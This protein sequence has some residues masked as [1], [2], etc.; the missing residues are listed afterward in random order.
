MFKNKDTTEEPAEEAE[1]IEPFEFVI[2]TQGK[3]FDEANDEMQEAFNVFNDG[4]KMSACTSFTLSGNSF[5]MDACQWI[6]EN[7]LINLHNLQKVDFSDIFTT[8]ERDKLPASLK[9]MIDAIIDKQIVSL[10]LSHNAFGPDGVSAYVE[11]LEKCPS[12]KI[13][14]VTNCGLGPQG[15]EMIAEAILK[16]EEMKLEE[17]SASRDRL[18][19]PGIEALSKVFS[20]H[21]T[22]KK[23]EVYQ[24]GIRK[25]L[26]H[27]FTALLDCAD[28]IEYVDVQ[29]NLIKRA[30]G[31]M[32]EFVKTCQK[33]K[34]FNISDTLIKKNQQKEV[35]DAIVESI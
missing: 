14:D 26:S 7:I 21:G 18:E 35:V 32:V 34:Y 4:D 5:G 6:A 10:K 23:I 12:L 20:A 8:R 2:P 27:L 16:N 33:V 13:L 1:P 3:F 29:D 22:L 25:G 31:E 30:T 15:S 17:F 19:N 28:T 24:N 11:F 9:F